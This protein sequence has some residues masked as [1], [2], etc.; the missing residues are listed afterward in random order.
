[1]TGFA[2]GRICYQVVLILRAFMQR[3]PFYFD[4]SYGC[5]S[6]DRGRGSEKNPQKMS[7]IV[8]LLSVHTAGMLG[9][10]N[11]IGIIILETYC[12]LLT[13]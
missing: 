11:T 8:L 10:R 1:M 3:V 7:Q 12:L 13:A 6:S 2:K 9:R 5:S 4:F